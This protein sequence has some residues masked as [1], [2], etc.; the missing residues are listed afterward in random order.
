MG[1]RGSPFP[2]VADR[3]VHQVEDIEEAAGRDLLLYQRVR[4]LAADVD[5]LASCV[6]AA[7]ER[8]LEV[9]LCWEKAGDAVVEA[10]CPCTAAHRGRL[11]RHIWAT[12]LLF[13]KSEGRIPGDA[14][15]SVEIAE[16]EIP[17][18]ERR[19]YTTLQSGL[20]SYFYHQH[21]EED[22]DDEERQAPWREELR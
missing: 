4:I 20:E 15:L 18:P 8:E 9:R 1:R 14:Q 10:T 13:E 19:R 11:C 17:W 3:L 12:I 7:D 22:P 21:R 16:E 5:R 6:R 2:R